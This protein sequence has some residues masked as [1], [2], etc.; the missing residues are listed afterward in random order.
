M[1]IQTTNTSASVELSARAEIDIQIA[2]AKQYP[3]DVMRC[4]SNVEAMV[5]M[6]DE[7]A[8]SC[9]YKLPR[10]GKSITGPSV[11]LAEI[12]ASNWGNLRCKTEIVG[13]DDKTVTARAS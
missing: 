5:K 9:T 3:R 8:L 11:R 4:L 12:L 13:T 10:G 6:D 2:T 7:L 1:E